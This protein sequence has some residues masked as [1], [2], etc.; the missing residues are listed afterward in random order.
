M[1]GRTQKKNSIFAS[2]LHSLGGY[3]KQ[4]TVTRLIFCGGGTVVNETGAENEWWLV[5]LDIYIII[6]VSP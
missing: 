5:L 2:S 4:T 3:N 1:D 6:S